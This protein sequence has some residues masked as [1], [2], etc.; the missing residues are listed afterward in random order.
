[1]IY[2]DHFVNAQISS[3]NEIGALVQR[4]TSCSKSKFE[5]KYRIE[6]CPW[7]NLEDLQDVIIA[8]THKITVGTIHLLFIPLS[9]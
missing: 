8:L 9:S 4:H 1:M 5:M 3:P 7:L 6:A 2:W